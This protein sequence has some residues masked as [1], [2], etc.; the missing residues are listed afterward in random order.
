MSNKIAR[1]TIWRALSE[2]FLDTEI[3]EL[4]YR[5][6]ARTI[7]ESELTLSEVE[8]ILWYEVYPVLASNLRAVAG[9]WDG[10]S[11]AWLLQNLNRCDKPRV[12]H[13][14]RSVVNEIKKSWSHVVEFLPENNNA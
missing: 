10:W 1:L 12:I 9:V 6:I 13:G 14:K 5:Y 8:H 3:N 2:L 7:N 4:T 11:D